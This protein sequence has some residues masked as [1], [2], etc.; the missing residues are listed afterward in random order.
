MSDVVADE[1]VLAPEA[2]L[3]HGQPAGLVRGATVVHTDCARYLKLIAALHKDGYTY[4]A[5][6][7]AVDH[8][9]NRTRVVPADIEAQRFEV[10]VVLRNLTA[11]AIIRIRCQVPAVE[12]TLP[13]LFQLY[14]GVEAMER[15]AYDLMG[16]RFD[17]HPDLTRIL[18]PDEWEGHPLRKDY[19]HGRVPVQFKYP[20]AT[21]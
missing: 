11:R 13:T 4:L 20:A 16:L 17:G 5:D 14:P 15:E 6:L 1:G 3:I 2:L 21:R 9:G 19:S 10:V 7:A 18:M 8:L 12:A